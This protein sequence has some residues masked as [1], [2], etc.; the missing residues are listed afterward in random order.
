MTTDLY[1]RIYPSPV[2]E[3]TLVAGPAGL[4]QLTWPVQPGGV[5]PA[6]GPPLDR[7]AD[8]A[9]AGVVAVLDEAVEQLDEYFAGKRT[10]FDLPLDPVGTEFQQRAWAALRRIPFGETRTYGQQA[11][12]I[13]SPSAVRAVGS[14]N[15]RNPI[16][17]IVP[18]HRVVGAD[19]SLTGF[20]GG[21]DAKRFLLDHEA[22]RGTLFP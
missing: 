10:E 21:L 9:P 7:L 22:R 18:C 14:A 1:R 5:A 15:G 2:G 3:L 16:S 4:R 17:I 13:G 11:Q 20:G 12:I 19:G 6:D 8:G